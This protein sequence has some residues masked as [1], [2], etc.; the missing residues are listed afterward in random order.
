MNLL[1][2]WFNRVMTI[3]NISTYDP[4]IYMGLS[5][6]LFL[7]PSIIIYLPRL[8]IFNA[9][10]WMLQSYVSFGND[11]LYV[12]RPHITHLIDRCMAPTMLLYVNLLVIHYI[13]W[14]LLFSANLIPCCVYLSGCLCL[15][16][17]WYR[18]FELCHIVWHV[19]ASFAVCVVLMISNDAHE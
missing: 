14:T 18:L 13:P 7:L 4:S 17:H 19:L 3:D 8:D 2:Y 6:L 15:Q 1:S 16:Y 11:Y 9:C 12:N 5:C 10:L